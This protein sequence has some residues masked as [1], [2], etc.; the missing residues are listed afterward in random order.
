MLI[1]TYTWQSIG[2]G[3]VSYNANNTKRQEPAN[4]K[5]CIYS[6]IEI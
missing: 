1:F 3:L 2:R 5:L 4:G 6:N